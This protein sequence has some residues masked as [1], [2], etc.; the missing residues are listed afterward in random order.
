[1]HLVLA[2]HPLSMGQ[3]A[4]ERRGEGISA[5][6]ETWP[7]AIRPTP[8][9]ERQGGHAGRLNKPM[10]YSCLASPGD[11]G[12]SLGWMSLMSQLCGSGHCATAWEGSLIFKREIIS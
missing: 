2:S 8:D 9:G 10:W 5:P 11:A 3:V 4:H 6:L 7:L 1:M 12:T